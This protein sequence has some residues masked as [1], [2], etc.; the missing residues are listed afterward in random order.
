MIHN[1]PRTYLDYILVLA[2]LIALIGYYCSSSA[3]YMA[4]AALMITLKFLVRPVWLAFNYKRLKGEGQ[5]YSGTVTDRELISL[6]QKGQP[7]R[8]VI[9]FTDNRGEVRHLTIRRASFPPTV[10]AEVSVL[11]CQNEPEN[12]LVMPRCWYIVATDL[13]AALFLTVFGILALL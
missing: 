5:V 13:F 8:V 12:F 4:P 3:V 7:H 6:F 2:V 11:F 10:G 9:R 1:P